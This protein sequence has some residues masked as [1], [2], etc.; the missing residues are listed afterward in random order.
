MSSE[1]EENF[2]DKKHSY[3]IKFKNDKIISTCPI[4]SQSCIVFKKKLNELKIKIKKI[5]EP[6]NIVLSFCGKN[7]F[8]Y[9]SD[10]HICATGFNLTGNWQ[11]IKGQFGEK[12]LGLNPI[13]KNMT[14][15][16]KYKK[17]KKEIILYQDDKKLDKII[18]MDLKETYGDYYP[19][20]L[21]KNGYEIKVVSE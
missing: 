11:I 21:M 19:V 18:K 4:T 20:I 9:E 14:Y 3:E 15:K 16:I 17:S 7:S 5:P 13:K 8:E 12:E 10:Q 6:N 2:V 1:E